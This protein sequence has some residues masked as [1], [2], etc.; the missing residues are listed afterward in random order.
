M[1]IATEAVIDTARGQ[2]RGNASKM[3]LAIWSN[4]SNDAVL[5]PWINVLR[6][7]LT[8]IRV[9]R[10]ERATSLDRIGNHEY[11]IPRAHAIWYLEP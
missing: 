7:S 5:R 10:A 1:G 11:D 4:S 3:Y 2:T 6:R 9:I 8:E